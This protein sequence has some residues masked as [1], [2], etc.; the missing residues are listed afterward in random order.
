MEEKN[1]TSEEKDIG[2]CCSED[3]KEEDK[4]NIPMNKRTQKLDRRKNNRVKKK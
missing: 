1:I 4:P 3:H 2:F